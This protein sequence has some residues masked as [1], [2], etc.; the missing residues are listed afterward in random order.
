[1]HN[2]KEVSVLLCISQP[3]N[4]C[5][6]KMKIVNIPNFFDYVM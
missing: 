6:A 2:E 1:M 3:I 4:A 5:I